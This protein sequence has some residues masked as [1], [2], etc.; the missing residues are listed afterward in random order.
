MRILLLLIG[1]ILSASFTRYLPESSQTRQ[2][3]A[4]SFCEIMEKPSA[5]LDIPMTFRAD[6]QLAYGGILL[7]SD[8]CKL[9]A[10]ALHFMK[11]FE[12]NS[13]PDAL[14]SF[15]QFETRQRERAAQKNDEKT[16]LDR[17]SI[18]VEGRLE[19]NPDYHLE[20]DPGPATLK[21]WDYHEE[22][23]F[24]VTRVISVGRSTRLLNPYPK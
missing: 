17:L 18:E 3:P 5:H 22:Y 13:N 10:V 7:S 24:V 14:A 19:K 21:A 23:A 15:E 1:V 12:K 9:P 11:D 16:K 2:L 6:A 4:K 8:R 20:F